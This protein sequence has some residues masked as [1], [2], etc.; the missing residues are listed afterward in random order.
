M[1]IYSVNCPHCMSTTTHSTKTSEEA[2]AAHTS[3]KK[4]SEL[5]EAMNT[6]AG[7]RNSDFSHGKDHND[8]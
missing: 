6:L 4:H 7:K 5:Q 1:P 2:E 3:G 8:K